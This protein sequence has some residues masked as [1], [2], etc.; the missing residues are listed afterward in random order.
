LRKEGEGVSSKNFT[1][2]FI[3]FV[4]EVGQ[5]DCSGEWIGKYDGGGDRR[6]NR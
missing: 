5:G 3:E 1:L 4:G 2:N 6:D